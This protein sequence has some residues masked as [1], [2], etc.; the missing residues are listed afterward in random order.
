MKFTSTCV[1]LVQ[2]RR[3]IKE[4]QFHRNGVEDKKKKEEFIV[5][6]LCSPTRLEFGPFNMFEKVGKGMYQNVK[7]MWRAIG[8]FVKV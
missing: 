5:V 3:T 1:H 7:G 4:L 8:F 2:C 6:C